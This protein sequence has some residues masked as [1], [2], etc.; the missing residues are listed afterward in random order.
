MGKWFLHRFYS[1][2]SEIRKHLPPTSIFNAQTL[3]IFMKKYGAV[4]IKPDNTHMG[5]GIM[6]AWKTRGGYAFVLLR[7]TTVKCASLDALYTE[8]KKRSF[9]QP[10]IIQKAIPL[11][12]IKGRPFDIRVMMMRNLRDRW[13]FF[14]LYSKVAG[15]NSIVTNVSSSRGYVTLFEKSMKQSLGYSNEK[16]A[17]VKN[18][19]IRL[20]HKICKRAGKIRYYQKIGNDFAVDKKGKI[21]LIEVNFKYPGFTGFS[22]LPNQKYYLGIKRMNNILRKRRRRG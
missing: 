1:R 14:G 4:Y 17:R 2:D 19:L 21:S 22:R 12:R 7:G 3:R 11:A 5:K 9:S 15:P 6:K 10:Y 18:R 20:S 13:Q 16:A 8:I